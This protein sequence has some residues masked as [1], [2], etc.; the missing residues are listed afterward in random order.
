MQK[1][2]Y[3]F[4]LAGGIWACTS[5][6]K[7]ATETPPAYQECYQAVVGQDTAL[8]K[9]NIVDGQV[10]GIL[11]YDFFEKDQSK[12]RVSGAWR[13]DTLI[14]DYNFYAEGQQSKSQVALLRKGDQ[15]LE[16]YGEVAEA[17]NSLRFADPGKLK[18]GDSFVFV[19]VD[20]GE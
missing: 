14:W 5:T 2:L 19:K 17:G 13:N 20:C 1:Y 12:G 15:L 4:L 16:G 8:L 7:Q 10:D 11:S 3:F 6:P 18:F 9:F